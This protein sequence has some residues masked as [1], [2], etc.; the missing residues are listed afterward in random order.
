MY[1]RLA[2]DEERLNFMF[3]L[4]EFEFLSNSSG[5]RGLLERALEPKDYEL[6]VLSDDIIYTAKMAE[7]KLSNGEHWRG[8]SPDYYV[9]LALPS[10]SLHR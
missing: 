5:F 3:E 6:K 10:R 9:D 8:E 4:L 2:V 1:I 7:D